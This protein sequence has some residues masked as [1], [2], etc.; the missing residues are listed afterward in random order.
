M[1]AQPRLLIIGRVCCP[2]RLVSGW[3]NEFDNS[4]LELDEHVNLIM[5]HSWVRDPP[6]ELAERSAFGQNA[7][8]DCARYVQRPRH[9][10]GITFGSERQRQFDRVRRARR[11]LGLDA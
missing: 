1:F 11:D 3:N 2:K 4:V 5:S 8:T 7:V 10:D 6:I 9:H